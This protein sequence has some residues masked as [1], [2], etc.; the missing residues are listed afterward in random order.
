M[1][2]PVEIGNRQDNFTI[3]I[4]VHIYPNG[5]NTLND[6]TF[7]QMDGLDNFRGWYGFNKRDACSFKV[8]TE[9]TVVVDRGRMSKQQNPIPVVHQNPGVREGIDRQ[10]CDLAR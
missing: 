9:D 5:S 3:S 7:R 2:Y 10:D 6:L 8:I 1:E 4:Q